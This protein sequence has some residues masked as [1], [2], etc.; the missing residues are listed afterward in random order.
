MSPFDKKHPPES[1][2]RPE[3]TAINLNFNI[4]RQGLSSFAAHLSEPSNTDQF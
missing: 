3:K 2:G 4:L 1:I